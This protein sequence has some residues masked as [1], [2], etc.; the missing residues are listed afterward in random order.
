MG[1]LVARPLAKAA[2]WLRI[3]RCRK[4]LTWEWPLQNILKNF[5]AGLGKNSEISKAAKNIFF[6]HT[7]SSTKKRNANTI[8]S[9]PI[10]HFRSA[11]P[12]QLNIFCVRV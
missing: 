11:W 9:K 5:L 1:N 12:F 7:L 2:R 10:R 4:C 6:F 3:Q 8:I